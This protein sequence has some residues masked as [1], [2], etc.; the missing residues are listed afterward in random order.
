MD[1]ILVG[2]PSHPGGMVVVVV[3]IVLCLGPAS[4]D[5]Q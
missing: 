3:L 2:G 4:Y 1:Y 5:R